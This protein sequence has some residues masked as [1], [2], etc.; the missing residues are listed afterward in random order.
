MS[1]LIT[2]F[3]RFTYHYGFL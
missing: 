3:L 2:L 1:N